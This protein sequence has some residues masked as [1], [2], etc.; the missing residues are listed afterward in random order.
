[1]STPLQSI[2]KKDRNV[3]PLEAAANPSAL[4]RIETVTAL[5]GLC[6]SSIYNL[7]AAGRF[8]DPVRLSTRCTRFRAGD[9]TAW[10]ASK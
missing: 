3:Q 5:T 7:I 10:L 2:E 8:V 1:M 9:V 4:L 6:R